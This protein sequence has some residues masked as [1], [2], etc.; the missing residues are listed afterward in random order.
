MAIRAAGALL[1]LLTGLVAS[2]G[3]EPGEGTPSG[4]AVPSVRDS[5]GVRIVANGE[6]PLGGWRAYSGVA[7]TRPEWVFETR[8]ILAADLDGRTERGGAGRG[9]DHLPRWV[10]VPGSRA[11]FLA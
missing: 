2:C 4:T 10:R 6:A 5:A 1:L 7:E 11:A 9:S 3:G 8:P